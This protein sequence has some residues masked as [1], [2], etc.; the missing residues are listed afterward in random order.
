MGVLVRELT[1]VR[2]SPMGVTVRVLVVE[3]LAVV[4]VAE[5]LAEAVVVVET[6]A[7][8]AVVVVVAML[9]VVVVEVSVEGAASSG[10]VSPSFISTL[11][12]I[13]DMMSSFS[14]FL[15]ASLALFFLVLDWLAFCFAT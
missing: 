1:R 3:I 6:W 14:L 11:C 2:A 12:P 15:A 4:V 10:G 9:A 5:I 13:R 8:V 7:A